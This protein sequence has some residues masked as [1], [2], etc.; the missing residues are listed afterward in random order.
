MIREKYFLWLLFSFIFSSAGCHGIAGNVIPE[1]GPSMEAV[2]EDMGVHKKANY[3]LP[4]R[5]ENSEIDLDAL[6]QN[7][8]NCFHS[9]ISDNKTENGF[10]KLPN[11]ELKI[12][13][14]P[15]FS[16]ADEIPIPGYYT[17]FNA[18]DRTHYALASE[19]I[20]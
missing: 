2:Y 4:R 15:H 1:T 8:S 11:P 18:Y 20:Y 13:I 17:V 3:T 9:A 6:R 19:F 5:D 10:R 7:K 12:Y 16:G 14:Y